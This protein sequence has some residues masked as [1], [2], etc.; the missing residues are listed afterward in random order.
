[1][2]TS[3]FPN[4]PLDKLFETTPTLDNEHK[5]ATIEFYKLQIELVNEQKE[6]SKTIKS[7]TKMTA[8]ATAI[9]SFA[10]IIQVVFTI[11]SYFDPK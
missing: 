5:K 9:M 4:I 2:S 6:F 8:I 7:A 3:D 11:L 1:M 10:I